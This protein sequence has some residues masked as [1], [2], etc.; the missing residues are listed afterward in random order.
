MNKK[1][2]LFEEHLKT[3]RSTNQVKPS[4]NAKSIKKS[5]IVK[6]TNLCKSIDKLQ[7]LKMQIEKETNDRKIIPSSAQME[8]KNA[9][10]LKQ[11]SL[12]LNTNQ[13]Y[14]NGT[15]QIVKV[16]KE[17][18]SSQNF[19]FM[20][21]L[22]LFNDKPKES[23]YIKIINKIPKLP[24]GITNDFKKSLDFMLISNNNKNEREKVKNLSNMSLLTVSSNN[25]NLKYRNG[26][27]KS[28]SKKRH[29]SSF[30]EKID[31]LLKKK[32]N[33]PIEKEQ[34]T[35][36]FTVEESK[37]KR[38]YLMNKISINVSKW[39]N[40]FTKVNIFEEVEKEEYQNAEYRDKMED[41]VL[42]DFITT[43]NS[44]PLLK[45]PKLRLSTTSLN[46]SNN[47]KEDNFNTNDLQRE[48]KA[49]DKKSKSNLKIND[50]TDIKLNNFNASK[51]ALFGIFDGH[52][53]ID[54]ALK[55]KELLSKE[56]HSKI[57]SCTSEDLLKELVIESFI[58]TD[59]KL[60]E[61]FSN[62]E[63][64]STCSICF[65]T[66][67]KLKTNRILT[68]ANIGDSHIYLISNKKAIRQTVDHKCTNEEEVKRLKDHHA[69]VFQDRL[70][71]Q[72]TVSRSFGDKS[73]KEYGLIALPDIVSITIKEK[74]ISV[75]KICEN[76]NYEY[77]L[78]V[79]LGSDGLWDVINE[80]DL[81]SIFVYN[82]NDNITT[83]ELSKSL[84]ELAKSKGTADN[85]SL[86]VIRL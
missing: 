7:I 2:C 22:K 26:L 78:F 59:N 49:K 80:D 42:C 36:D 9:T 75:G 41:V 73:M 63:M 24:N 54:V 51:L 40:I 18:P 8:Y 17:K 86:I 14:L 21:T 34:Q 47:L 82:S 45:R 15:T 16:T 35:K 55:A 53:G 32:E 57:T 33:T 72:L 79:V 85:T 56:I 4:S 28:S 83:K 60:L 61:I 10:K 77:D 1:L 25:S 20:K 38:E 67:N 37:L 48:N 76:S 39:I 46:N 30:Q 31:K 66:K 27:V 50:S 13:N 6:K 23:K 5:N 29:S 84:I 11:S 69:V 65:L 19:N 52:G 3:F 43:I 70:F 44:S 62:E 12:D 74:Q 58:N 64:G 81:M 68:I 71:G